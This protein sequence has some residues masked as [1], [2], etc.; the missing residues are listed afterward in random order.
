MVV[1][2]HT[3]SAV[4][5]Q[6]ASGRQ[7]NGQTRAPSPKSGYGFVTVILDA[8]ISRAGP[9]I[10]ILDEPHKHGG[11]PRLPGQR[12]AQRLRHEVRPWRALCQCLH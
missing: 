8:L 2:D 1:N 6:L 7:T 9:L 5:P 12:D 11:N 3:R 10:E 4:L